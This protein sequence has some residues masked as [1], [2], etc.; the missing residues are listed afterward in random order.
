MPGR[1]RRIIGPIGL[2]LICLLTIQPPGPLAADSG[3]LEAGRLPSVLLGRDLVYSTYLPPGHDAGRTPPQAA[4]QDRAPGQDRASDPNRPVDS[5]QSDWPVLMLLHGHGGNE[6]DWLHAGRLQTTADRLI[7]EGR[8]APL[9]VA[10]PDGDNSWYVDNA[11]PGGAGPIAQTLLDEF[12]NHLAAEYGASLG[13]ERTAIAGLSMGGYGALRLSFGNPDRY[14]AV[15]S[16][17]GAMFSPEPDRDDFSTLQLDLFNIAFGDPFDPDRF[18]RASP[19]SLIAGL[20]A[21]AQP[22][23]LLMA[24]DDD[25]FALDLETMRLHLAL[26]KAGIESEIRIT[27]G[28]HDWRLW[29]DHLETALL[30]VDAAWRAQAAK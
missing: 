15:V 23:I 6:R 13:R 27:D 16:M 21:A 8:I 26:E 28:G 14:A 29:A 2:W 10:M 7:A 3:V 1:N 19:F 22:A 9:I 20:S 18:E 24:G 12:P 11:D 30:F 5:D 17:S 25:F 4:H